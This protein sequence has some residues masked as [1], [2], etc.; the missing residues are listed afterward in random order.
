MTGLPT[1]SSSPSKS[2][3]AILEGKEPQ[4]A[5]L[6][7]HAIEHRLHLLLFGHRARL[8]QEGRRMVPISFP[9]AATLVLVAFDGRIAKIA[10]IELLAHHHA[11]PIVGRDFV[12]D[13]GYDLVEAPTFGIIS[14]CNKIGALVGDELLG[15]GF[16]S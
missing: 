4:T 13:C 10:I 2:T 8:L 3:I 9:H 5:C 16:F 15:A 1:T 12:D 7:D 6:D 14:R 11:D